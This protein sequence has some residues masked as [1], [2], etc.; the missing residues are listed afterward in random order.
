MNA[1]SDEILQRKR[2][3]REQTS[4]ARS[5]LADRD[6][7]SERIQARVAVLPAYA[8]ARVVH[9]YVAVRSEVGSRP[10]LTALLVGGKQM[11]VPWC[12]N[13]GELTLFR[14]TDLEQLAPSRFGLLEPRTEL[15][16]LPAHQVAPSDLD[17]VLLPGVAFDRRGGRLGHGA[18]Y[19]DRL[20]RHVRPDALLVGLAFECQMAD[21][22][23]MLE[24]DVFLD[25]VV[26]ENAVYPGRGRGS[27]P[28]T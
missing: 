23:P 26:T 17:V 2:A 6:A 7:R 4:A 28:G 14:L 15:R 1:V 25:A 24:H 27:R 10:I 22:V 18:G 8:A 13:A 19:Y 12:D 5:A 3:L 9:C 11:V 16:H 21:E 20:L